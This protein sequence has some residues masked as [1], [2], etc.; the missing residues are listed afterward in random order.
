MASLRD[1]LEQAVAA[2]RLSRNEA[3]KVAGD[4]DE[5]E[6]HLTLSGEVSP[7]AART[8]AEQSV[9]DARRRTTAKKKRDAALQLI[10][11]HR[12]TQ[13]VLNHPHGVLAGVTSLLV[14]D[15][16]RAARGPNLDY[17]STAVLGDLHRIF[18]E[19]LAKY[20][21]KNLGLSQDKQGVENMVR[22]LHGQDT[23]DAVAKNAAALWSKTA[24]AARQRFNRAGGAIPK[25]ADWGMPQWHDPVRVT[26]AAPRLPGIGN[27]WRG[28]R[29]FVEGKRKWIE[30]ITPLLDRGKLLN[31][32][33]APMN[34]LEY[35]VMMDKMYD[36]IRTNGASDLIP[37]R[38]GG[39]KLAN[40]R[41]DHRVLT[42]KDADA[43]LEYH[44]KYGH[45]DIYTTLTDH[46]NSM[47]HDIA[48][49]EILGPDPEATYRYLK[50]LAL[51]RGDLTPGIASAR[52]DAYWNV[53][54]GKANQVES[55]S[56]ADGSAAVRHYLASALLGS[57]YLSAISDVAFTRQTARFNGLS[58]ASVLRRQLSL[59]N[60]NNA[61]GRLAAVKMGLVAEA[62]VTRALAA[63]RFVEVTGAGFAAKVA[64]TTMRASLLSPWTDA[65]RKAF[66]M[67]FMAFVAEQAGRGFDELHPKLQDGLTGYGITRDDWDVLRATEL[68][69]HDGVKFFSVENLMNRADLDEGARVNL[70][71]KVQE[72]VL[73]ETDF[74]VPVPDSRARAVLTG[75]TKR[76]TVIGEA[77]RDIAL[78]KSFPV[79]VITSH[80]LR[81]IQQTG[82]G[83]K[84]A[85]LGQ[86]TIATTVLG[87]VALQAKDISK[88]RKARDMD[89]PEFWSAAFIQG[90][91]A[92]IFGDFIY[93]GLR[94][95]NRFNQSLLNTAIGPV[96]SLVTD[97]S[98]V[99]L[100]NIGQLLK[101]ED[102][103]LPAEVVQFMR[104]YTPGGSL[105]YT[106]LAW[107]RGVIDQLTRM[108][109]PK[110][111][112]R[113]SRMVRKRRK[114]YGQDYWWRP[115]E[116][117][118]RTLPFN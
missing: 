93:S 66:G 57:A 108:T 99:T 7:E 78:F 89:T 118:P 115:G 58:A 98:S 96:G 47:A 53:A 56:L 76:G 6:K 42:F 90:G 34:D 9:I 40:R 55:V 113:F 20:R 2:G 11:I 5:I 64:D 26:Q 1:C 12:V 116:T 100:G 103:N 39:R 68:L 86:L 87:A 83:N 60:P 14:K 43:W 19:A 79:T 67:E 92:G 62:W 54:S 71:T 25:R 41:Q 31:E 17:R 107:E 117:A 52:L 65:G 82:V 84:M 104:A 38:Q 29:D 91:G 102:T 48:K 22:E 106:R 35:Q 81:G 16:A 24:E 101:G 50:D 59:M 44:H 75:G 45:A 85:Y 36:T 3:N 95:T 49:L 63:N 74:A 110:A 37:G 111:R 80:L 33:G 27:R 97:I 13:Q 18:A 30:D 73:T 72:M 10:A 77:L 8:Q 21:T 114:E 46:L 23:G 109:D 51:K 4:L 69:D 70:A 32:T 105:W 94:G 112:K 28:Q 61:A 88:G 15:T